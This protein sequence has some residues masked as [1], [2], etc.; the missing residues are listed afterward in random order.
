VIGPYGPVLIA[1]LVCMALA[2]VCLA[3]AVWR[4]PIGTQV[5]ILVAAAA[6]TIFVLSD[7]IRRAPGAF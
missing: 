2:N 1:A 6:A 3:A 4:G 5:L 7:F